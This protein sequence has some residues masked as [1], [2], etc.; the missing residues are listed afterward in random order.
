VLEASGEAEER[1]EKES[2]V[3][4]LAKSSGRQAPAGPKACRALAPLFDAEHPD[5]IL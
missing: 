3:W 4:Q 5:V 1:T 2:S